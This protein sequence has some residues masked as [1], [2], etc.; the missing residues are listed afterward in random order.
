MHPLV[1]ALQAGLVL[2]ACVRNRVQVE[3]KYAAAHAASGTAGP[4][5]LGASPTIADLSIVA[6]LAR[7]NVL[8]PLYRGA[9]PLLAGGD[10]PLLAAMFEAFQARPSYAATTPAAELLAAAYCE[11]VGA[12]LPAPAA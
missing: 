10:T 7:F 3:A 6:F 12:K 11:F 5:F 8:L 2:R 4:Y 9:E 1:A